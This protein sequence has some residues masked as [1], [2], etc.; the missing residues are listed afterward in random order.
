MSQINVSGLTF[1]YEGSYD[2]IFENTSFTI[3]TDWKLG[4]VGRNGKGKTTFLNL[5][6][7][8]YEYKGSIQTSVYFDYF[9]YD[10]PKGR[11]ELPTIDIL[12]YI[13]PDY[14][15]WKICVE[16][17]KLEC[18]AEM[19]YRPYKTL[20]YGEQTKVM[21]AV[22]FSRN[23][24][25]LLI[26]E[27]TNHLDM[28]TRKVVSKYL[29]SKKSF[30]LVSHDRWLL[31]SCIDHV[32]VLNRNGITIEKG[33]FTSWWDNKQ[34]NDNYEKSQDARLRKEIGKLEESARRSGEWADK[35]EGTKI[36]FDPV[37][38]HDRGVGT[39]AYIGEKS[40]RMQKRRKS[41]ENRQQQAISEKSQLLKNIEEVVDLKLM[42]LQHHKETYVNIKEFS[43][44]YAEKHVIQNFN[45]ELKR[46][47]RVILR[48]K[49]GSGKSSIIEAIL[50]SKGVDVISGV[51]LSKGE[52]TRRQ[53][54][55][56]GTPNGLRISYINQDTS[57][58][59]G[60]MD[61]YIERINVD[62]SLFKAVLRQLDFERVQFEKKLEDLSEGQKKKVLIA[63]SLL[64]QAHLYVW[65][66]PLN[67]IDI[68][69]RIQIEKMILKYQP[70]M[71]IVEHEQSFG[72]KVAT[73]AV[74]I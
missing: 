26:D 1:C 29:T 72:D 28:E 41:L 53:E 21:L 5:L 38:E 74:E 24:C 3:D 46:G 14:E 31:D 63:G 65:D 60:T 18:D 4:F 27:P 9:P 73:R 6:L 37:K 16:L 70:T 36:G 48:G 71:L 11:M 40:K 23:N 22:L 55:M 62:N 66:E 33:N 52:T 57:Y 25:F 34:K 8:K 68:F 20:S 51:H 17:E 47:E 45:M 43:I 42:P 10:I 69:S 59:S 64:Q 56:L 58:L 39:R 67:Y 49:N 32:L 19:L 30:I 61:D 44:S 7:G 2:N 12:E 15:L 54:G 35:V 13:Q 50:S